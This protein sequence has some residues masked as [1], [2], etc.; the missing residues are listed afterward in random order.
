MTGYNR[1]CEH[2]SLQAAAVDV[3]FVLMN[4]V[5]IFISGKSDGCRRCHSSLINLAQSVKLRT[6]SFI[7]K[8]L[9]IDYCHKL[10]EETALGPLVPKRYSTVGILE[11]LLN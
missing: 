9:L 3:H 11:V 2:W 10:A 4:V 1:R 7:L 6:V 8:I 5:V